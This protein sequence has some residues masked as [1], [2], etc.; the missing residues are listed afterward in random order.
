MPGIVS[1]QFLDKNGNVLSSK[2]SET[3]RRAGSNM[4]MVSGFLA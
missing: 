1:Y 3:L 4:K 2:N